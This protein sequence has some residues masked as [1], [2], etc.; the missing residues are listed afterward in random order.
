MPR[1][2]RQSK[3]PVEKLITQVSQLDNIVQAI[4]EGADKP[5]FV[6][7]IISL[8]KLKEVEESKK[9][10]LN[11]DGNETVKILQTYPGLS[12]VCLS[13]LK[14]KCSEYKSLGVLDQYKTDQESSRVSKKGPKKNK[15]EESTPVVEN[16]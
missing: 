1:G 6:S 5:D 7:S 2:K 4:L 12:K 15:V 3:N 13:F 11:S 16:T 14:S 9:T 10:K 8:R